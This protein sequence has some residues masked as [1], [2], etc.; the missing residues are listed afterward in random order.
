MFCTSKGHSDCDIC[1]HIP[2][3]RTDS[4]KRK[5][6]AGKIR[7][8]KSVDV[9]YSSMVQPRRNLLDGTRYDVQRIRLPEDDAHLHKLLCRRQPP[10]GLLTILF[11]L[12]ST[13]SV[14]ECNTID[15]SATSRRHYRREGMDYAYETGDPNGHKFTMTDT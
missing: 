5:S 2:S 10:R 3:Y 13:F 14:C 12:R 9:I 1:S 4:S 6:S 7:S 15:P 8:F 11:R